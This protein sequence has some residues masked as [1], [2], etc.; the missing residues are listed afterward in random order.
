MSGLGHA[1]LLVQ[2]RGSQTDCR[3]ASVAWS[4]PACWCHSRV[5]L[6]CTGCRGLLS[7]REDF[8]L[9]EAGTYLVGAGCPL[10]IPLAFLALATL[11]LA[12]SLALLHSSHLGCETLRSL[13]ADSTGSGPALSA[14]AA[15]C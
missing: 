1:A 8:A 13:A 14:A 3:A 4:I 15:G 7:A 5:A 10:D 9:L 11:A 2:I 12:A 6:K